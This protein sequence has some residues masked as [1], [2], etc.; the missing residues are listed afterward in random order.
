ME[1]KVLS[2]KNQKKVEDYLVDVTKRLFDVTESLDAI[3]AV[4]GMEKRALITKG[5]PFAYQQGLIDVVTELR[6]YASGER[7]LDEEKENVR[8]DRMGKTE[9]EVFDSQPE[10]YT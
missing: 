1:R 6:D 9:V 5:L 10:G 4:I 8:K 7:D 2:D 3:F